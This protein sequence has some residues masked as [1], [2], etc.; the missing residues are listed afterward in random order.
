[1][2]E[3][4]SARRLWWERRSAVVERLLF[5]RPPLVVG[6]VWLPHTASAPVWLQTTWKAYQNINVIADRM[7][8][9]S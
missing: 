8:S 3:E 6:T 5:R 2:P 7:L 4:I 1:M 9:D